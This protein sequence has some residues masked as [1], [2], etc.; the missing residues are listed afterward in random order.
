LIAYNHY[1]QGIRSVAARM[2]NFASEF[3]AKVETLYSSNL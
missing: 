2:N 3:V 1:L